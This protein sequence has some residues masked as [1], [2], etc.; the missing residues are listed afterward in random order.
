MCIATYVALLHARH[1]YCICIVAACVLTA[2]DSIAACILLCLGHG[3]W[4]HCTRAGS[5]ATCVLLLHVCWAWQAALLHVCYCCMCVSVI[6]ACVLLLH[7]CYCW[8]RVITACML[9]LHV[10]GC[11]RN[12]LPW[13]APLL[14]ML[15]SHACYPYM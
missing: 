13:Q 9:S 15:L 8:M 4:H 3:R 6:S 7:A 1:C 2:A 12:S 10:C 5:I 11:C 14:H